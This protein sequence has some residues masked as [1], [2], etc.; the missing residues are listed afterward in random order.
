MVDNGIALVA[1]LCTAGVP[2]L[3]ELGRLPRR[4]VGCRRP[5]GAGPAPSLRVRRPR[6]RRAPG[7]A[8]L[9]LLVSIL[10]LPLLGGA[11]VAARRGR[12]WSAWVGVASNGAALALGIWPAV[13]VLRTGPL[14]GGAGVAARRR[15]ERVHGH[16]HRRDPAAGL[17]ARRPHLARELHQTVGAPRRR[18]PRSTA[19]WSRPSWPSCCSPSWRPTSGCCGWPSRPPPSSPTFLV[20]HR[21]T[22]GSLEASWKYIVI[23]SVGIALAFLGTVL[24]YLAAP[25]RR[26]PLGPCPRLDVAHGARPP[27]RPVGDAA[28]LRAAR[29]RLRHQGRPRPD[30]Q[31]AARRPQPGARPGLRPSCPACC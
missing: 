6:S 14:L 3:I 19:C 4:A 13:R 30:A 9:M 20:G 15:P 22:K 17:V 23:C 1:F 28:G 29:P 2:F 5:H 24:V 12:P 16:R 26:R 10:V 21:R 25:A 8:R 11:A 18:V 27:P 31:L 7:A